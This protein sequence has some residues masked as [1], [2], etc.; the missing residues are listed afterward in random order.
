MQFNL[1]KGN[2]YLPYILLVGL[3]IG[4]ANYLMNEHLNWIQSVLL[5]LCTSFLIGYSLV[6]IAANKS[7]F[8]QKIKPSWKLYSVL[9]LAFLII[10]VIATE[11]EHIIRTL[12]FFNEAYL[13]FSVGKMYLFNG[14]ISLFLGFSF[15]M[16]NHFFPGEISNLDDGQK[17]TADEE[18]EAEDSNE[19]FPEVSKIPVKRG[20]SIMLIPVE[21][22]VFFEAFDNYSFVYDLKG[23]K[24][25]C[26]YSLLFLQKRLGK[27]FMRVH[28][29]YIINTY[30]IKQ[31]KPYSNGRY[32]INFYAS[33][34]LEVTSSKGY[35][36]SVR[37]LIKIN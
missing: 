22:I 18:E 23:E 10:G 9:F 30:H 12:V 29:K 7:F 15:F 19:H 2:R 4:S 20:D 25:L 3:G 36:D 33:S 35:L 13:P 11:V 27:N 21:E 37:K 32:I 17:Q 8:E 31:I 34:S 1:N 6:T 24:R 28:R 14:I 5:S 16:N 26:D